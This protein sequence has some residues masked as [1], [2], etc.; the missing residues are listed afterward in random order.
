VIKTRP[1]P[2]DQDRVM[3][4]LQ[5]LELKDRKLG[6]ARSG[7]ARAMDITTAIDRLQEKGQLTFPELSPELLNACVRDY[8]TAPLRATR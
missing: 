6:E 7:R 1:N 8:V 2:T 3:G 5:D 4:W